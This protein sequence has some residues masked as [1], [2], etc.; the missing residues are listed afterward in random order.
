[1]NVFFVIYSFYVFFCCKTAIATLCSELTFGV[2]LT[3][4]PPRFASVFNTINSWTNQSCPP[5]ALLIFVP[6]KY[7]RF[8]P[9]NRNAT[10]SK[11]TLRSCA[12]RLREQLS[13]QI[14]H[15]R[16]YVVETERDYGPILKYAG[17]F[18]F[19]QNNK[20]HN[21]ASVDYWIIGDDD[22]RYRTTVVE[23][24]Y[25]SLISLQHNAW[26]SNRSIVASDVSGLALA[27]AVDDSTFA[28]VMTHYRHDIRLT[29]LSSQSTIASHESQDP[30]FRQGLVSQSITHVQGVDTIMI[31]TQL[32]KSLRVFN[33]DLL[34]A[35]LTWIFNWCPDSFYQDDYIISL[36]LHIAGISIVSLWDGLSVA[37]HI[38]GV[39]KYHNQ[40]HTNNNVFIREYITQQCIV[41]NYKLIQEFFLS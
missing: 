39:S 9:H 29:I 41:E 8:R 13:E 33:T 32:I 10:H 2:A 18:D 34:D 30:S 12:V 11:E 19:V 14:A 6:K 26:A 40:L 1:M 5:F 23:A 17:L 35:F 7:R 37:G 21:L 4:I 22:V 28:S 38:D 27:Y 24:Y 36:L 16:I 3:T 15:G 25:D 20:M 31:S